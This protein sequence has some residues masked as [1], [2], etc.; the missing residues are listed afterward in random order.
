MITIGRQATTDGPGMNLKY[1]TQ[2]KAT[3]PALLFNG[4]ADGV[5]LTYKIKNTSVPKLKFRFAYGK[6]Y[7]WQ[8]PGYG[9]VAEN[10]GIKD[11]DV[12][13]LFAEG[14]ID[15]ENMGRNLWIITGVKTINLI[16][17]PYD[18]N[19]TT[20][21]NLGDYEHFGIYFENLKAFDTKLN[22]FLSYAYC[23]PHG[24]GKVGITDLNNDGV[25]ETPVKLLKKSGYA[26][27]LGF[28]YDASRHWK[29]GYEYNY[30]SKYWFSFSTNLLDP[31]NKLA[32]R[33]HVHDFYLMYKM[34]IFQYLRAGLTYGRC[35][36]N[37]MG[38]YYAVNG[39]PDRIDMKVKYLYVT[40][41]VRF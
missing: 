39:E 41:D 5:V 31:T 32:I 2:R 16:T 22:Y 30:G 38:M 28:R 8:D 1:D 6:G 3:Y 21:Q 20:N 19:A 7:Q 12:Y 29:Y 17:N 27:H 11:T 36:Y 24:N 10:P 14:S 35:D 13:A 18:T 40:Y 34:D 4:A 37:F 26:Y 9:W 15:S 25:P 33:G 23:K